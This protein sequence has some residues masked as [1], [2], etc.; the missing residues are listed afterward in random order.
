MLTCNLS[1]SCTGLVGAVIFVGMFGGCYCWGI[2]SDKYG[3]RLGYMA[4]VLFTGVFG[5][6]SAFSQTLWVLLVLRFI[7]G[8][9]LGGAPVS[10]SLF[11]EYVP[12]SS[13]GLALMVN[14]V[15]VCVQLCLLSLITFVNVTKTHNLR[16]CSGP[17][18]L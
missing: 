11:A 4:T 8:F 9:G 14:Q 6:L 15:C 12:S 17:L 5:F 13:R 3:R 1:S 2:L 16:R 18:E 10:Y 7:V